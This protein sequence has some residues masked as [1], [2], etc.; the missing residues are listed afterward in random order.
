MAREPLTVPCAD[1]Q[2][3]HAS[4]KYVVPT[5]GRADV[6]WATEP[7][8][9]LT[10]KLEDVTS[11]HRIRGG[12]AGHAHRGREVVGPP[13]LPADRLEA[14]LGKPRV[15]ELGSIDLYRPRRQDVQLGP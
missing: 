8:F 4:D 12:D 6:S 3:T 1:A 14:R 15:D 10:L 13:T 5:T 11:V 7:F 2:R 9:L